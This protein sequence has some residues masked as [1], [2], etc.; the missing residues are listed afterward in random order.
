MSPFAGCDTGLNCTA[1]FF[2]LPG[3]HIIE[4]NGGVR[5]ESLRASRY[6]WID[7]ALFGQLRP[8]LK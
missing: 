2:A 8:G 4:V 7:S 5:L 6:I 1:Q 3:W